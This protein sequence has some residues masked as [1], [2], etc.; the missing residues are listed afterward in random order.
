MLL[1]LVVTIGVI[2]SQLN[3]SMNDVV[4]SLQSKGYSQVFHYDWKAK[5]YFLKHILGGM[6]ITIAMTGLDQEIMQKNISCKNLC[7]AQKNMIL[8]V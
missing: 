3:F 7:D 5:N 1:A 6:F 8:L 4:S 2:M